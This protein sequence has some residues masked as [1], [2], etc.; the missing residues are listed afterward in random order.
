MI[1]IFDPPFNNNYAGTWIT[2]NE[3]QM[4]IM[5]LG[6]DKGIPSPSVDNLVMRFNLNYFHTGDKVTANNTLLSLWKSHKP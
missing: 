1:F 6:L 2:P 5:N 3:L 4:T